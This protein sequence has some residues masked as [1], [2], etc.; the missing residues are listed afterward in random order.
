MWWQ[1]VRL[2][3]GALSLKI[4]AHTI[5]LLLL[6]KVRMEPLLSLRTTVAALAKG[7]MDLSPRASVKTEDEFGELAQDLN[8]F[9]DRI[10]LIVHDLDKILSEVVARAR[11]GGQRLPAHRDTMAYFTGHY[12]PE[13]ALY[14]D[15][16]ASPLLHADLSRLPPALVLTAGYDPLRDEGPGLRA[17]RLTE[18]GQPA[19]HL[20]FERQ[21]PRL[22]PDGQGARRG[23]HRG[24]AVRRRAAPRAARLTAQAAARRAFQAPKI[25]ISPGIRIIAQM[26][27][28]RLLLAPTGGCRTGSRP[29]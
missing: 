3:A 13:P 26:I 14:A 29:A 25:T 28:S 4:L 9:L 27:L 21:D 6:L 10:S 1:E 12:I 17:A 7:V 11:A 22:H 23:E 15:W 16:R 2:T 24:A 8:H 18:A 20:C 5:V 19:S